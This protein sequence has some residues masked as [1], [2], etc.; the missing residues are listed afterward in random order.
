VTPTVTLTPTVTA[1][2]TPTQTPIGFPSID[3]KP[4]TQGSDL[5]SWLLLSVLSVFALASCLASLRFRS[6]R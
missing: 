6:R 1:S 4:I 5:P 2:P 3:I